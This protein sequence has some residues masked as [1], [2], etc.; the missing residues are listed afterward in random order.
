MSDT[1]WGN[2]ADWYDNV[3]ND[4]D[5]YQQKVILPN[6]L[7]IAAP[8][9]GMKI[10]DVGCGQGFFSHA[11]AKAGADVVGIDISRELIAIAQKNAAKN[12]MF[13]A[14]S[15]DDLS[16]LRN[17]TYDVA[18]SVLAIQNIEHIA[19][20]FKEISRTLKKNGKFVMILNH[21]AFRIPKSSSWGFDEKQNTQYRRIDA[22]LSESRTEIEMHPGKKGSAKTVSFHRSLQVYS[23]ILSN[24]GFA[25]S[26]L[27]EW[28]S[29]KNSESGPR[30]SAEDR[31]RKE[32]PLFLCVECVKVD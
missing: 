11:L 21:P 10:L 19:K 20:A 15:A 32:I 5:S 22:Y 28:T 1:S 12:E 27:E 8:S 23:K 31:A 30:K 24:A 6:I 16:K 2:V 17:E 25:M 4:T 18:L 9:K 29:H 26:R 7:R 3:V 13:F 14:A